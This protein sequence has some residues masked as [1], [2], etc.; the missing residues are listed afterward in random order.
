MANLPQ[1]GSTTIQLA[2]TISPFAQPTAPSP[3]TYDIWGSITING[4][5]Y[6]SPDAGYFVIKGAERSYRWD[7]QNGMMLQGAIEILRGV[8]PPE[9]TLE[10]Y[11]WADEQWETVIEIISGFQYNL[12]NIIKTGNVGPLGTLVVRGIN[13]YHPVLDLVGI[14]Q[15]NIRACG[16]PEQVS[17]DHLWKATYKLQEYFPPIQ[18]PAQDQDTAP[19]QPNDPLA[20]EL[21]NKATQVQQLT[22]QVAQQNWVSLS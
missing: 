7:V 10:H 14:S 8:T 17:D 6:R 1:T 13:I 20:P 19:Q 12:K 11:F 4:I 16:A 5:A 2:T 9:F 21:Q 22:Q 15:I 18:L 3:V